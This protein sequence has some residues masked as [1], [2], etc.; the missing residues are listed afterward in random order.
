MR[1]KKEQIRGPSGF[2]GVRGKKNYNYIESDSENNIDEP[3][4]Y[5]DEY[6]ES[7]VKRKPQGFVGLRGK[8]SET[9]EFIKKR[10]PVTGF[11][12]MRGKKE[13]FVS[14]KNNKFLLMIMTIL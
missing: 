8:K 1:G 3:S 12:G 11:F 13:P 7:Q 6:Y 2:L 9:P 4:D 10:V 5:M 14:D